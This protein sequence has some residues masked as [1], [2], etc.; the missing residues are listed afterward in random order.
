MSQTYRVLCL[1]EAVSPITHAARSAGNELL[2]A[3]EPVV[4]PR[5]VAWVPFLSGNAL[6]HR[7]VREPG[8]RW[9]ISRYGLAGQLTLAGLNFLLHGGSLTEGGGRRSPQR[10]ADMYRLFPLLRLLGG[11]L[12]DQ[13]VAGWLL[14][15][16]GT[17]VCRENA[18]ALAALLPEGWTL[19][20]A[21]LRPAEDFVSGFQYVRGDARARDVRLLADAAGEGED[22]GGED[23]TQM[24]FAGQA[25]TRGA[26][27]LHAFTLPHVSELELG[28]LLWSLQ[29][30][31][32]AGGTVGGQGARGH[33]R[34]RTAVHA[35]ADA[36]AAVRAYL[37]HA[38]AVRDE[39]VA[40]LH[41]AFARK[42]AGKP[43]RPKKPAKDAAP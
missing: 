12:P 20:D 36:A 32:A 17:L 23:S 39:A 10:I 25:V 15:G 42:A 8:V 18:E 29:L 43:P 28:A 34:L 1:S 5:G 41:A 6:R 35:G 21:P 33:G 16:R 14:S 24:I 26:C 4:T 31:Q 30:W 7:L 2:I 37:D 3:R 27:F 13:I 11:S 22:E 9:L 19:P 38:D 40:W